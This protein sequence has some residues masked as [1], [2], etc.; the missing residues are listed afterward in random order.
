MWEALEDTAQPGSSGNVVPAAVFVALEISSGHPW[1][2]DMTDSG[3]WGDRRALITA[4]SPTMLQGWS[5][6]AFTTVAREEPHSTSVRRL[7][8]LMGCLQTPFTFAV[9]QCSGA[10]RQHPR[11]A[12][13]IL[14]LEADFSGWN[15]ETKA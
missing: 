4:R 13:E 3:T 11:F 12:W 9:W 2:G 1:E 8:S 10:W 5:S 7:G 15:L 14:A 6:N